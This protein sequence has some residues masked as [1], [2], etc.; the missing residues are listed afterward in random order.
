MP[1]EKKI[2]KRTISPDLIPIKDETWLIQPLAVTTMRHDFSKTQIKVLVSLI[3]KLQNKI[4]EK[5]T[6]PCRDLFSGDDFD[7]DG[8]IPVQLYYKDLGVSDS[9]YSTLEDSLKMLSHIPVEIAVKGKDKK[10]DWVKSTN[11]CDVYIYDNVKY[12]KYAVIK[13]SPDIADRL[14]S[15][16]FGYHKLGKEVIF[17]ARNKY[18]QRIYMI[19]EAWIEKGWCRLD[20]LDFR[21]SLRLE[22]KYTTYYDFEKRVLKPACKE[23]KETAEQGFCDCYFDY[24]PEYAPGQKRSEYPPNLYFKITK[25]QSEMD[26]QLQEIVRNYQAQFALYVQ[27][28]FKFVRVNADKLSTYITNDN[29]PGAIKKIQELKHYIDDHSS[30]INDVPSYVYKSFLNY[31]GVTEAEDAQVMEIKDL[32]NM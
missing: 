19:L 28:Y 23:L 7:E 15:I 6:N 30:E 2:L 13:M 16:E 11:L 25:V 32:P 4:H 1:K 21:K 31:F 9:N 26:K 14:T 18:T 27:K 3:E 5:L 29:Y 24:K 22:N 10:R 12:N 8:K 17:S 20:M